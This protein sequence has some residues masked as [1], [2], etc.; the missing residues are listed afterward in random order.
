VTLPSGDLF[1]LTAALV[2]VPSVSH[3]ESALVDL[4]EAEL[5]PLGHLTVDRVGDNLVA[6]TELGRPRRLVLGGHT[7]TVP[8]NGNERARIEGDRLYGL[9][10]T[11][12]KGGIAALLELARSVTEPAV[13]VTYVLYAKEEVSRVHNGL[14][15]IEAARPELL[16]GDVALLGEPTLGALE[17]GCQGSMRVSVTL[18][19]A[20]AVFSGFA[21]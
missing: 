10:A 20:R 2:D 14:L 6:R 4:L 21:A 1:A 11:D 15:E 5:R 13:D 19:G 18:S 12:M 17:A 3:Q 9:G 16:D 7:D 8:P